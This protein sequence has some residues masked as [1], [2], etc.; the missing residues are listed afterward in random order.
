VQ[1]V[2]VGQVPVSVSDPLPNLC[3]S[4]GVHVRL[5]FISYL[6]ALYARVCGLGAVCVTYSVGGLKLANITAQA[7]AEKS[8]VVISGVPGL[9]ERIQHPLLHHK[10]RDFD[11]QHKVF[12][13]LTIASAVFDNPDTA[14]TE[15]DRVLAMALRYRTHLR[16]FREG[17]ASRTCSN[18]F[19]GRGCI[20]EKSMY[21][22]FD[23][24]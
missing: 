3:I 5:L 20:R 15:I 18:H 14:F 8:L 23:S 6:S 2:W 21:F 16:S 24:T 19:F 1:K 17:I 9:N 22:V 10:V 4:Q 13:E 7:Y 11:T 12:Q